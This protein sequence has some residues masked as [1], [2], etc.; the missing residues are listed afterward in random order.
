M[1]G[2]SRKK[3]VRA[4]QLQRYETALFYYGV[5]ADQDTH[6]R[7]ETQICA[8]RK[9][10]QVRSRSPQNAL[11]CTSIIILNYSSLCNSSVNSDIYVAATCYGGVWL[12]IM[13]QISAA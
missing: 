1:E 3:C 5:Y 2:N 4:L 6:T 7:Q 8:R 12:R 13:M 11:H 9:T 10:G